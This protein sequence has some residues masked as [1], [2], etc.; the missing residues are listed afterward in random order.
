[1][2]TRIKPHAVPLDDCDC[3]DH[4]T[5]LGERF[6]AASWAG[7]RKS[8]KGFFHC[9][10]APSVNESGP[11]VGAAR[12]A[13]SEPPY[14]LRRRERVC[15]DTPTQLAYRRGVEYCGADN[16]APPGGVSYR[17]FRSRSTGVAMDVT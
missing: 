12:A 13:E 9:A 11:S 2:A 6:I 1:M 3:H 16:R 5:K 4:R 14:T 8:N 7:N 15:R 17:V 10:I